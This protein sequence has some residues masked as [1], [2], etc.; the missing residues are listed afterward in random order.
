M[1]DLENS[2][3][4]AC[5]K[6]FAQN[7]R[8]MR[9][10]LSQAELLYYKY[11]KE[12][13]FL[14]I[15]KSYCESMNSL[16]NDLSL[17]GL[18]SH[19]F[20]SFREYLMSYV[21]SDRFISLQS[22]A[23]KIKTDLSSVKY[24][25][26]TKGLRVQVRNYESELDYSVEVE[27]TFEKFKQGAVK[28]Y[29]VNFPNLLEMNHVEAQILDG[30]AQIYPDI[31]SQLDS[32]YAT[33]R[34]YPDATIVLFDR[35]I[36]F[37]VAYLDYIARFK[38]IGLE[39]C[40]PEISVTDKEVYDFKGF[41][42]ALAGKLLNESLSIVTNGFYLRDKERVLVITGP[43]QGGKTTFARTFGQ[44]H[45]LANIG[46]PVPGSEARF[47]L[48]DKLFTH[49]EKEEKIANLRGKLEDD[50]VRIHKI[51][52]VATPN[53]IIIMNEILT[54]TTLQD[55]IFLSKEIMKKIGE[56]DLL[57]VWVTFIDELASFS[58]HT[59]SMVSLADPLNLDL[60]TFKIVRKP[61][62]GLAYAL[63]IAEK[64]GLLYENLKARI[65]S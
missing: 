58:Q 43:N 21:R 17:I 55:A 30:V 41:D 15:L 63:S 27:E 36:Q 53:S 54:S 8:T 14:D 38:G 44:L 29:K 5:I 31:F 34:D 7:M 22:E 18:K 25:V 45:F 6:S 46:C 64:Y 48:F 59:V 13:L 42:L 32:F 20:Q 35:E 37:Y 28:N 52:H 62:D 50:L 10:Y 40:Y 11:Q 23:E 3:L 9:H 60:R 65:K 39:F 33:N 26:F 12:S 16:A 1:Q 61:A 19:G 56:K 2:V 24:C 51:L 4:F 49:F 57:C 47:F